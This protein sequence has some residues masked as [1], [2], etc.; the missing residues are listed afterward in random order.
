M[1]KVCPRMI[2]SGI[3]E[4]LR[5]SRKTEISSKNWDFF[6]KL[7]FSRK[8]E[9]FSKNWDF[10]ISFPWLKS[11]AWALDQDIQISNFK[12]RKDMW[13][14]ILWNRPDDSLKKYIF[15]SLISGRGLFLFLRLFRSKPLPKKT[16]TENIY[17]EV[18]YNTKKISALFYRSI[19]AEYFAFLP[20]LFGFFFLLFL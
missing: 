13:K 11:R 20:F 15:F 8:T 6:E 4:N 1:V 17:R 3:F 9:I 2:L 18:K 7:R 12:K 5:F 16:I 19:P 10:Q 14:Y